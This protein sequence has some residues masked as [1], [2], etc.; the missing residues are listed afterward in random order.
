MAMAFRIFLCRRPGRPRKVFWSEH[1]KFS[2]KNRTVL[3]VANAGDAAAADLNGDGYVDLVIPGGAEPRTEAGQVKA[4]SGSA[5]WWGGKDGFSLTRRTFLPTLAASSVTLADLNHTGRL[6][7][8]FAQNSDHET[9]DVPCYIYLNSPN[10]FFPE[11]R[12]DLQGFGTNQIL[13]DDFDGNGLMDVVLVNGESGQARH[14]GVTELPGATGSQVNGLPLYIFRGNAFRQYGA[15]NLIRVPEASP[16][17]NLAFADMEDAGQAA[18][19]Y[20]RKHGRSLVIR[21]DIYRYPQAHESTE[22]GLPFRANAINVADFNHDGIL[23]VLVLPLEGP[24]GA[25]V[26]GRGS[27]KYWVQP[28]EFNHHA[29]HSA[30]GDLN[31]DGILD[32]VACGPGEISILRGSMEGGVFHFEEPVVFPSDMLHVRVSLADFTGNGWLDILCQN[33]QNFATKTYDVESWILLNDHGNFSLKNKRTFPSFG[34]EGGSLARLGEPGK[35][36]FV[37]A[38]YQANLSRRVGTF[39]M[40]ADKEG[41]PT[42]QGQQRLPA[43]SSCGNL[44]LDFDGDGYQDIVVFNHMG[45]DQS[46]GTLAPIGGNHG[47]GS[48][49]YW[50]GK[51]GF[52]VENA[53]RIPSF[54]PHLRIAVDAGNIGQREPFE[55]YTSD[56]ISNSAKSETCKLTISGR[57]N[58]KQNVTPEILVGEKDSKADAVIVLPVVLVQSPTSVSYRVAIPPGKTFRYRLKLNSSNTGAGPIV[59]SVMLEETPQR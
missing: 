34:G 38:N 39:V 48:T 30:V 52:S 44:V 47:F 25:I 21:Y 28:F 23:D 15:A 37:E 29:Y 22:I 55:V 41:F 40:P 31:R 59:S 20:L 36:D 16:E 54:G 4:P 51:Q 11:N 33:V 2:V 7:I 26:F 6:D 57:F 42:A 8:L 45:I 50:G 1:G 43:S 12:L 24:K 9:F 58:Q 53:T 14:D 35:L 17:T 27:R 49:M 32:A 5:I 10:G 19:V 18:L 46:N 56:Y 3:E 13:A